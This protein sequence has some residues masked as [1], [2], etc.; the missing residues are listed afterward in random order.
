MTFSWN[1]VL[2]DIKDP[3]V[4]LVTGCIDTFWKGVFL[5]QPL[6]KAVGL[7]DVMILDFCL[8]LS[9]TTTGLD[10]ALGD[11]TTWLAELEPS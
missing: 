6:A 5:E 7:L 3:M 1:C 4:N 10:V 9:H 2:S 8:P 11:T